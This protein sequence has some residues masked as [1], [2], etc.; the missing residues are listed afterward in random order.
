M[1]KET[2]EIDRLQVLVP[3]K[4]GA[5]GWELPAP[6]Q[7]GPHFHHISGGALQTA[8]SPA[9]CVTLASCFS[10][11]QLLWPC[12]SLSSISPPIRRG[13]YLTVGVRI[14]EIKYVRS[15]WKNV[16][17]IKCLSITIL[18]TSLEETSRGLSSQDI[19]TKPLFELFVL[20]HSHQS[21]T[22]SLIYVLN[23]FM[24]FLD[25]LS[26]F[27]MRLHAK[28]IVMSNITIISNLMEL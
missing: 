11:P 4:W 3:T 12:I 13:T 16:A 15:C 1:M 25:Y 21:L 8:Y 27:G 10:V 5:G 17:F 24:V 6:L 26:C 22:E 23:Q 18:S 9:I 28:D 19:W 7:E 14:N 20:N 2:Q